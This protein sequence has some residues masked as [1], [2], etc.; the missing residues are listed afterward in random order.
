MAR[1]R[2]AVD[3]ALV[4]P[5][6]APGEEFHWTLESLKAQTIPFRLFIVDDGNDVRPDYESL[7]RGMNFRLIEFERNRGVTAAMNAGLEAALAEDGIDFIARLDSGDW[8]YPQRLELQ[9]RFLVEHPDIDICGAD[10]EIF[11][12]DM[13]FAYLSRLPQR[14]EDIV[15]GLFY[16]MQVQNPATMVRARLYREIGLQVDDFDAAEDYEFFRRAAA[17][18]A[19]FANIGQPLIKKVLYASSISTIKRRRQIRSRVGIQ[20]RYRDLSN[21]HCW[22][23]MARTLVL[24]CLPNPAQEL[25]RK[26]LYGPGQKRGGGAARAESGP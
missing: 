5:V 13:R 8:A 11:D 26:L 23:G 24:L 18:G 10:A 4:L 25:I 6:Y 1:A 21:L 9:R 2:Q 20:W 17:A 14:H 12:K 19:R 3:T 22:L 16:N 15:R 7:L